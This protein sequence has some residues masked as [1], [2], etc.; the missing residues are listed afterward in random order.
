MNNIRVLVLDPTGLNPATHWRLYEPF[1]LI[2]QEY[3]GQ[4]EV[5]YSDGRG[6]LLQSLR[7]FDVIVYYITLNEGITE[8]LKQ[9]KNQGVKLIL[10]CDDDVFNLDPSSPDWEDYTSQQNH[11][12]YN[13]QLAD[14]IWFAT[15]F[16]RDGYDKAAGSKVVIKN[17]VLPETIPDIQPKKKE[18]VLWRGSH[19]Q[20]I[21]YHWGESWY[22][23]YEQW[24][25]AWYW[26][27]YL[28]PWVTRDKRNHRIGKVPPENFLQK[29]RSIDFKYLWKPLKP[30]R[31]N[32]AKTSISWIEA[33]QCGAVLVTNYA[34]NPEWEY[35]VS[36]F[37]DAKAAHAGIWKESAERIKDE[38]NLFD[39]NKLRVT[40]LCEITGKNVVT[41]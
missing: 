4:I 7:L 16:L 29:L 13:F 11:L 2:D 23:A 19:S 21:N 32:D 20:T 39:W 27:G 9:A 34:E 31:Q 17:A 5:A 28:P 30:C 8:I 35:C 40:R 10:D 41:K 18:A 22:K 33:T 36:T 25:E 26:F 6:L 1:N 14:E 3:R 24:P 12:V 38:Y 37:E 15:D